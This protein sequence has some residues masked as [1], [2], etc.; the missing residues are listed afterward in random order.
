VFSVLN[1]SDFFKLWETARCD[2]TRSKT[3][4]EISQCWQCSSS[5]TETL[6]HRGCVSEFIEALLPGTQTAK[7]KVHRDPI[8]Q[9][10]PVEGRHGR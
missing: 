7:E 2:N 6:S 5:H 10:G 9:Q 8:A 4:S 3:G 1:T